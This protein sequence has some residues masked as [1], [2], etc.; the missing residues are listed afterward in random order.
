[1]SSR[2]IAIPAETEPFGLILESGRLDFTGVACAAVP[3]R[4]VF[5]CIR[6]LRPLR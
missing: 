2:A 5:T 6:S 3:F 4:S 1:M